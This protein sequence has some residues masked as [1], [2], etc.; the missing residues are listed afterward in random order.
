[1]IEA[2]ACGT[3]VIAYARGSVPDI[4]SDEVN[5]FVVSSIEQAVAAVERVHTLSRRQCRASF[6]QHFTAQGMAQQYLA[7]FTHL[8]QQAQTKK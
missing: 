1:M 7:L 5:G 8:I 2:L 3:P 4:I 6:E